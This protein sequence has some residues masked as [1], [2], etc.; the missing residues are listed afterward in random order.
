MSVLGVLLIAIGIGDITRSLTPHLWRAQAAGVLTVVVCAA[1]AGLWHLGDLAM[2]VW[3]AAICVAWIRFAERAERTGT[4]QAAALTVFGVGVLGLSLLSGWASPAAGLLTRWLDWVGLAAVPPDRALLILG[5]LLLQLSTGNQLVRLVL[6]TV[7]VIRPAGEPQ[8][9]DRLKS[10]R[11]LGPMERLLILGL[12]LGGQPAM[13]AAV[14]AAKGIIR[15][16][17]LNAQRKDTTGS[18]ID[19][20]TEYFLIGSFASWLVAMA[21]VMLAAG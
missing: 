1:L 13:A 3:S 11:L 6:G 9:S 20:I 4:G 19:E 17:E 10:G 5:A 15:F 21:G 16:P 7:G 8:P 12:G 14:V 18:S 2:L